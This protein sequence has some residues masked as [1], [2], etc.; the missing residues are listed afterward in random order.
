MPA[1]LKEQA[2]WDY[3]V[4]VAEHFKSLDESCK[5]DAGNKQQMMLFHSYFSHNLK[6]VDFWLSYCIFAKVSS[7]FYHNSQKASRIKRWQCMIL[8][9][10]KSCSSCPCLHAV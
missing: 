5:L 10:I 1:I 6:T 2:L 7:V 9:S 4:F 8:R 3:S